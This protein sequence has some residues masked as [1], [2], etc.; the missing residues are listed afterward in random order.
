MK[1]IKDENKIQNLIDNYNKINASNFTFITDPVKVE[2]D[3][4]TFDIKI[5]SE[6]LLP[7]NIP[8]KKSILEKYKTKGGWKFDFSTGV[9]F[10][11]GDEDFLGREIQYKPV[12][13]ANVT[14]E[15]KD[16]SNRALLSIGALM[17][18]YKRKCGKVQI[19]F[20]PGL[21]TTTGF[22]ELNFHLGLSAIFGRKNRIVFTGGLTFREAKILDTNYEYD[23]IYKKDEL[24]ESP[25]TIKVFPRTGG[26]VSL[27]YNFSK[28][29]SQ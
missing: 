7:C 2:A 9:F 25:P 26:F 6:G 11:F 17:H 21:S 27:T 24:P 8:N 4:V 23:T 22:D 3:E 18:I 1:K 29:K 19:A 5:S 12:D 28:F 10:N 20:S 16:G 14:I 13:T 15:S